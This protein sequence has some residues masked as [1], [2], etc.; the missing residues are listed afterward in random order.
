MAEVISVKNK[1]I[2][3]VQWAFLN[4]V[5]WICGFFYIFLA[6]SPDS[7]EFST[8]TN[9]LA[10]LPFGASIGIFQWLKFRKY[11]VNVLKWVFATSFGWSIL[12]TLYSIAKD[13]HWTNYNFPEWVSMSGLVIAILIGG[14]II[15]YLQSAI[16]KNIILNPKL[17][18]MAH[19]IGLLLLLGLASFGYWQRRLLINISYEFGFLYQWLFGFMVIFII[20]LGIS[21]PTGYILLKYSNIDFEIKDAG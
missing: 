2:F 4:L 17:W 12:F 21:I 18:I 16:L 8:L 11:K 7:I 15:G 14:V 5:G 13:S 1:K 20:S 6:S 9:F 3:L 19:V 10:L